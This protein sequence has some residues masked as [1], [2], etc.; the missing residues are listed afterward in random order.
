[1][2]GYAS[3]WADGVDY[4]FSI[5]GIED[6]KLE[7]RL[8][9]RSLLVSLAD[10]K[11]ANMAALNRR[12]K[13]DLKSFK[14]VMQEHGY[15]G[16]SLKQ[17]IT[18]DSGKKKV[19]LTIDKGALYTIEN[20][21]IEWGGEQKPDVEAISSLAFP[22]NQTALPETLLD[23]EQQLFNALMQ[24]GYYE[25]QSKGKELRVH[26]N[27]QSVS[28]RLS[29]VPG[30]KAV[31]GATDITGFKRLEEPFVRRRIAWNEGEVFNIEKIARTRKKLNRSGVISNTEVQYG[32]VTRGN[33]LPV[34]L[35]VKEGKHRSVGAG[36]AYSTT[37]ELVGNVFWEHR[38]LFG[39]AEKFRVK[40]EGGTQTYG[41]SANLNKPDLWGN[42]KLGWQNSVVFKREL[43]EAFDKDTAT[44]GTTLNYKYSGTSAI[45]GGFTIEQNRIEE[46]GEDKESFT[47]VSVPLTYRYDNTNDALDP[48]EGL[49]FNVGITPYQ[50]LNEQNS[51]VVTS[52]GASHYLPLGENFV[53]ANRA[54]A[55]VIHGQRLEDVPADKRLYA[56]GGGSVRGYGYQLLGPLDAENDPTGGRMAFEVGTEGRVKVTED[57]ELIGF[58]EGGRVSED[59]EFNSDAD[60]FWSAGGGVRYHTPI[61][62]LRFDLA[63]PLDK[64]DVDNEFQF[65]ISIGQA[66]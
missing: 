64:R 44:Y 51:F 28:V 62:P 41:L 40:L 57:I 47:M 15:F 31:F 49:R 21:D 11:P 14:I 53:W 5:T 56:G 29:I 43:L 42:E 6:E 23:A 38:N 17:D 4:N 26:H 27:K 58:I 20:F 36:V 18:E 52:T 3:A 8:K 16:A 37:L 22:L 54:R 1:M 7:S 61:G 48:R 39:G 9:E 60:F 65:Y 10:K 25:P 46:G 59:M 32:E 24:N 50:V 33:A 35:A 66:F 63:V 45:S 13:S 55:A 12:I 19:T 30:P 2:A 34:T